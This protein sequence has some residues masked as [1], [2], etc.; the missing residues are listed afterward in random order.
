MTMHDF[1]DKYFKMDPET[2]VLI[3]DGGGLE[4]GMVVLV[5][6]DNMR[7]YPERVMSSIQAWELER[8]RDNNQWAIISGVEKYESTDGGV[9][10]FIATRWD[11]TQKKRSLAR[12]LAWYVKKDSLPASEDGPEYDADL[13]DVE[14]ILQK[15]LSGMEDSYGWEEA[16]RDIVDLFY[17]E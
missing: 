8:M 5:A 17:D 6:D 7:L 9:V 1:V 3:P 13:R 11:G 10:S 15:M 14:G 16:A 4:N 12:S 2:T